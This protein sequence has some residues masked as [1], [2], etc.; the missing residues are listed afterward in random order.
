MLEE[1]KHILKTRMQNR[2]ATRKIYVRQALHTRA[3]R[4]NVV[5]RAFNL[6]IRHTLQRN[7][8]VLGE[9]VTMLATLIARIGYMP[10]KR[11]ILHNQSS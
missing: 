11:K 7:R 2:V 4:Q 5:Q 3:H 6:L 10:L 1:R 8:V 9:D